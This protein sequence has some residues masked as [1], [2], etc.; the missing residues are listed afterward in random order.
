MIALLTR[1]NANMVK[2]INDMAVEIAQRIDG[3]QA[4]LLQEVEAF[5]HTPEITLGT[6]NLFKKNAVAAT[7]EASRDIGLIMV[8]KKE[9]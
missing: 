3:L 6:C 1:S 5:M 2:R 4:E 7:I 8:K 9:D